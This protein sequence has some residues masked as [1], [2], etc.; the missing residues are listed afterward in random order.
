MTDVHTCEVKLSRES[1]VLAEANQVTITP[2][3]ECLQRVRVICVACTSVVA[4]YCNAIYTALG[5]LAHQPAYAIQQHTA[6]ST[7]VHLAS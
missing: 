7:I 5:L 3:I 2:H 1:A 6:T 4:V